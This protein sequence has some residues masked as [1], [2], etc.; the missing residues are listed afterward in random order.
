MKV[1]IIHLGVMADRYYDQFLQCCKHFKFFYLF[2]SEWRHFNLIYINYQE[3][4]LT[5]QKTEGQKL[6]PPM[7]VPLCLC[8]NVENQSQHLK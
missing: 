1:V 5:S 8:S 3:A 4:V 2:I 7:A 6:L